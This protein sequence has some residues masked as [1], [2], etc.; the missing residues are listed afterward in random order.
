MENK[1][2]IYFY[3][4]IKG[5]YRYFSQWHE[6]DFT[7]PKQIIKKLVNFDIETDTLKLKSAEHWMMIMKAL[8]FSDINS[9]KKL[10]DPK[11]DAKNAKAIGRAVKNFDGN[12]WDKWKLLFVTIGNI[13]KFSGELYN[14]LQSTNDSILVEASPVDRIWGIGISV[15]DAENGVKWNGQNLLGK[16]LVIARE[17]LKQDK[18][19]NVDFD[20]LEEIKNNVLKKI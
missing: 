8:L 2:Y 3:G 13:Y 20:L 12:E 5:P 16:A 11:T 15:T 10:I 19:G 1:K 6:K 4:H 14:V 17:Y 18:S 7:I 9:Y